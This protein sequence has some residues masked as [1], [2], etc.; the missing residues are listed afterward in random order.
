MTASGETWYPGVDA[1]CTL[2]HVKR[3]TQ[4]SSTCNVLGESVAFQG[5]G[6]LLGETGC[7]CCGVSLELYQ[8]GLGL[9]MQESLKE[10]GFSKA[11]SFPP[12]KSNRK[13]YTHCHFS[14]VIGDSVVTL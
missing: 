2:D 7:L 10:K 3:E 1:C 13:C 8:R 6:A 14:S 9:N 12:W 11:F 5:G 4:S